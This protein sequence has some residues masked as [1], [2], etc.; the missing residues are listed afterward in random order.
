MRKALKLLKT[1]KNK[2]YFS[3][4]LGSLR[5]KKQRFP[6]A[7]LH[8]ISKTNS[9]FHAK[10]RITGKVSLLFSEVFS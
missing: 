8:K 2:K 3:R 10:Y 4:S 5:I 7:I 1:S 6:E 9:S